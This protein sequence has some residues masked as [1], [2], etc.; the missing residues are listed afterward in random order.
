[1]ILLGWL[2]F[3]RSVCSTGD[4]LL[5]VVLFRLHDLAFSAVEGSVSGLPPASPDFAASL[6]VS[7]LNSVVAMPEAQWTVVLAL[8][9]TSHLSDA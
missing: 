2:P 6:E 4:V 7:V 8:E 5:P 9:E 3:L 1:M